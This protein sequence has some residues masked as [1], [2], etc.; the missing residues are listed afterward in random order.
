[1]C[2]ISDP[3]VSARFVEEC[4]ELHNG[5]NIWV[6]NAGADVLT[7]EAAEWTFE[8]KLQRL[9]QVDVAG[10]IRLSRA[11]GQKMASQGGTIV[12]IGWDQADV[13]MEGDSGEM[14]AATKGAVMAF[15]KSLARS[16]APNVRVNCVAPG[17]IKTAWGDDASSYWQRRAREESL[18]NR[19]GTPE[20][21]AQAR[22]VFGVAGR[23]IY[24]RASD[25]GKRRIPRRV[26]RRIFVASFELTQV[27]KNFMLPGYLQLV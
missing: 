9:W 15:T 12:N 8:Q 26:C 13:G 14:F 5:V 27:C 19:W 20:D 6:N 4:W 18:L 2:D 22:P 24:H 10:T 11:I 3:S 7:G 21:V 23:V 1:M 25:Q 17:W 16:L